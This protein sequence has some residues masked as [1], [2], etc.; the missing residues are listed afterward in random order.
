LDYL[1]YDRLGIKEVH[2]HLSGGDRELHEW[3]A[4]CGIEPALYVGERQ[5]AALAK[6]SEQRDLTPRELLD[7]AVDDLADKYRQ[8]SGA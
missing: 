8:R 6:L 5:E 7:K 2:R 1:N 4:D 3:R